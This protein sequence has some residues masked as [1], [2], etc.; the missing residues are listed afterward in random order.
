MSIILRWVPI[1]GADIAT[2]NVYRSMIGFTTINEAPFGFISGEILQLRINSTT[3]Q[4]IIIPSDFNILDLVEFLNGELEGATAYK[5]L[6]SNH[7]IIRSDIREEPGVIE[8]VGGT[9]LAKMGVSTR[10]ISEKSETVH[11][12]SVPYSELEYEDP[13]GVLEDF[14]AITTIDG[15]GNESNMSTLRQA[16]NYTGPICVI[17]GCI[18]DLQGMRIPDI[19]VLA[20]IVTPPEGV[21]HTSIIKNEIHILTGEDG[22]FSL[23]VLQGS[24]V[25]FEIDDARVSD[26]ITIPD[27]PYVF[28]DD[29]PID[30]EYKFQD[31]R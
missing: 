12:G 10:I 21:E 18:T 11:I 3:T 17:E 20:R 7:L 25:I 28:F 23:P 31:R 6:D 1:E 27:L 16:I 29:L 19:R 30:Y 9:A 4:N 13:D 24:R 14:Y 5:A 22:R 15:L 8:V 2:Y 26:P